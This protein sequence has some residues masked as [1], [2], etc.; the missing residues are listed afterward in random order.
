MQTRAHVR[1]DALAPIASGLLLGMDCCSSAA[2]NKVCMVGDG[3]SEQNLF[4]AEGEKDWGP[5]CK[6]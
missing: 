6:P 4:R 1:I 3:K 5:M 2:L